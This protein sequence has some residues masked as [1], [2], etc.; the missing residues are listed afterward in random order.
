MLAKIKNIDPRS[1]TD[2][3]QLQEL[4]TMLINVVE[5]QAIVVGEL[6]GENQELRNEINRL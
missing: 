3:A 1:I 5:S 2:F 4:V 6:R